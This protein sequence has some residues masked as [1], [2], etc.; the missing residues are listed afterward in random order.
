MPGAGA[1]STPPSARH[2]FALLLYGAVLRAHSVR[3]EPRIQHNPSGEV[4]I[5]RRHEGALVGLSPPNKA[6]IPPN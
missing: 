6:P 3:G 5:V 1:R 2:W 4:A